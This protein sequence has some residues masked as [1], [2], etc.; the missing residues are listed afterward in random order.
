MTITRGS[1]LTREDKRMFESGE[2][3]LETLLILS[4]RTEGV[5]AVD[6]AEELGFSRA[7]VSRALARLKNEKYITVDEEDHIRFTREGR[8]LAERIYERHRVLTEGFMLLGVDEKTA[9]EDACKIE[10]DL[11]DASFEAVKKHIEQAKNRK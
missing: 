7:S 9:S 4:G 10:H 2:M 3:Y 11:S 5:H 8:A 6:A 1:A